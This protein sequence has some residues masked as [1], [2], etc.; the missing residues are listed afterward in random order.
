MRARKNASQLVLMIN[1]PQLNLYLDLLWKEVRVL[2]RFLEQNTF[3]FI[4]RYDTV[5][6][7]W[8]TVHY[9]L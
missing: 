3:G 9:I 7:T 2:Y 6:R 1:D 5:Q 8:Y 4:F